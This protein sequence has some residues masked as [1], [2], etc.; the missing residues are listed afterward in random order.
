MRIS[1]VVPVR[2]EQDSIRTLIESLLSQ[3][4]PPD[5]I[6]IT[7]GGST[8]RTAEIIRTYVERGAPI[9]LISSGPALP[10]RGRN[11]A[12]ALATGDWLAFIDAGIKPSKDWL[13][14]FANRIRQQSADVVY[15]S[16]EPRTHSLFTECAAIAYVPPPGEVNGV[17]VR[18]RSIACA[19]MRRNV[20]Q[21]VGGFPEDLRSAEDLLFME[22]IDDAGFSVVYTEKASVVWDLQPTIAKTFARFVPYA[23]NNIR[24]GLWKRWQR[25]IFARYVFLVLSAVP[26]LFLGYRWFLVP[27]MFWVLML[28]ARSAVGMWRNRL[29]YPAPVARWLLRSVVLVPLLAVLD[30]ALFTGTFEWLL[31]DKLGLGK[32]SESV[33]HGA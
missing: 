13:E 18:S 19:F 4:L 6:V 2:N 29:A 32:Q 14:Q 33:A 10:G 15:G 28:I 27:F 25:P 3:T 12:S 17:V 11:L 21:S 26:T 20:W 31:K 9:Q 22:K 8:D 24:A 1:V 16:C 7:D 5:E 30:A 23:R